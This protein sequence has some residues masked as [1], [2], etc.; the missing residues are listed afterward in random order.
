MRRR[1]SA[2]RGLA[3]LALALAGLACRAPREALGALPGGLTPRQLNLLLV[4]LDT[5]RADRIGAYA[6]L[7]GTREFVATPNLDA[8]AAR[9][10]LFADAVSVT[11]LTLPAHSTILTGLLPAA[12]GVR[13]NGG[14]RLPPE[15]STLAEL[16]AGR[17]WRTGGFVAAYVLDRK[18]GIAQGFETYFDDFDLAKFKTVSMGDIQRRGDEVVAHA[19]AWIAE[20][21]STPFFAWVHLYDPHAPYDPPEPYK[22]AYP[23][24]TYDG[25]IAWTDHLVGELLAGLER[26]G[27]RE[28]T[29]V[30]VVGDHGENL[31]DHGETGHGFFV[32]RSV[33]DVPLVLAGPYPRLA[34]RT[35]DAVVGQADLAPTLAALVDAGPGL[36][37]G[38]GRSL[39]PL[40]A[41]TAGGDPPPAYS[42]TFYARFHYGWS[43]L[44][45]LTTSRWR[46]IEAPRPELYDLDADPHETVNLADSERRVVADLR[47]RLAEL[48]RA[49][50]PAAAPAPL[51]EDEETAAK[52]AALGYLGGA[53]GGDR[54]S[55][56]ELADPK[57]K[58][59][60]YNRMGRA[61][62][63]ARGDEPGRSLADL[64]AVV[65]EDPGVIDAWFVWGNVCYRQ[66]DFVCA[67]AKYRETLARRPDHDWA[68]IGLADTLVAEGKVDDAVVGYRH[69]LERDAGNV[70]VRYRLAQVLLDAGRDADAEREFAATLAAAPKTA[71]AEVGRA[72][73][74]Y[75]RHDLAAA[76][77]ALDRALA[78][79]PRTRWGRFNRALV[80]EE[81]GRFAEALAAYRAELA[82]YPD[83]IEARFN[84][85]RLL[86]RSG[87]AATA[88]TE[89][90]RVVAERADFAPARFYLAQA[91]LARGDVAA[92]EREARA[93]LAREARGPLAALGHYV[94][95][96]CLNRAGRAVEAE[97]EAELGRK[98][99]R[100]AGAGGQ[101][102][103]R[104]RGEG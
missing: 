57:D 98:L 72:V 22:S 88:I 6:R 101:A 56:R 87:D 102:E 96:D 15:R 92:A 42:E 19:L 9:G 18:W 44:R 89:L 78:I 67:T 91:H 25:E 71:R 65:A 54:R 77:A 93:G 84:L 82:D 60:I 104:E 4:T 40:L 70:Q 74:A 75:R 29:I 26:A 76:A 31:G 49:T 12:H 94:L 85:G 73:V 68:M 90:A 103:R 2:P 79:D 51:E 30:A 80:L 35:I 69:F 95:A 28:R 43:E 46:F 97:R 1:R 11:P 37:P 21:K 17:G 24:R 33:A 8:L 61:R 64:E 62:E 47:A 23:G 5:T 41:G 38:Q 34:G 50:P 10:T 58:L 52:L 39:V 59:A 55:F 3:W 100:E 48:D 14:F 36:E 99:E 86:A 63:L 16:L 32:Y 53:G 20:V 83:G 13:D 7:R 27:V 45:A 81:Q 66:R